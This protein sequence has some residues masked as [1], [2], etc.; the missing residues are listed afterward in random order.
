MTVIL[1]LSAFYSLVIFLEEKKWE[2]HKW[3]DLQSSGD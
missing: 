1:I 3:A 2:K